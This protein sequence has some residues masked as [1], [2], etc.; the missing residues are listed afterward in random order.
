M[1][2]EEFKGKKGKEKTRRNNFLNMNHEEKKQKG[3]LSC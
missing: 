1:A 3:T 2:K